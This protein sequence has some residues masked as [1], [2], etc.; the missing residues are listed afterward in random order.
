ML[1][2]LKPLLLIKKS[3]GFFS[4]V[5]GIKICQ[6]KVLLPIMFIQFRLLACHCLCAS[7]KL[8]KA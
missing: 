4:P 2:F 3:P 1:H 6:H 7:I 8:R 5:G